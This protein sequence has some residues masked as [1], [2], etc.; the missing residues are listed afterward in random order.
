MLIT[1]VKFLVKAVIL[2]QIF[3][4]FIIKYNLAFKIVIV[5]EFMVWKI[6]YY[7]KSELKFYLSVRAYYET[8]FFY[9]Y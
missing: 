6:V 3:Q 8:K 4:C 1:L 7:I 2:S 5:D 9:V